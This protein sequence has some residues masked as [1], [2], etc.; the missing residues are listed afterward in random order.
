MSDAGQSDDDSRGSPGGTT[1]GRQST[2]A[3]DRDGTT[4]DATD[5]QSGDDTAGSPPCHRGGGRAGA[6]A[7]GDGRLPWNDAARAGAKTSLLKFVVSNRDGTPLSKVASEVLG[8]E[9]SGDADYQLARRFFD[10]HS[11]YFNLTNRGAENA[12]LWVSPTVEALHLSQQ[13]AN[14]KTSGRRG[15]ALSDGRNWGETGDARLNRTSS[16]CYV[17][18]A[19]RGA[20]TSY[21]RTSHGSTRKSGR[22]PSAVASRRRCRRQATNTVTR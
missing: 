21:S 10:R 4:G 11:V 13:Y 19:V 17:G 22:R 16:N 3:G 5:G 15:D 14:G 2:V 8:S 9:R 18:F 20:T 1:T 12:V 7:R 6:R